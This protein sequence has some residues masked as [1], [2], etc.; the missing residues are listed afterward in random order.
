MNLGKLNEDN[1]IATRKILPSNEEPSILSKTRKEEMMQKLSL[2]GKQEINLLPKEGLHCLKSRMLYTKDVDY[3]MDYLKE[4]DEKM[5]MKIH[6][7]KPPCSSTLILSHSTIQITP[8]VTQKHQG[9][10]EGRTYSI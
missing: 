5:H 6:G 9:V 3:Y 1:D 4:Q 8:N 7:R 2:Q 10:L